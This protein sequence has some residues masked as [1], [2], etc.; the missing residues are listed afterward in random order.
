MVGMLEGLGLLKNSPAVKSDAAVCAIRS[1][2]KESF[3]VANISMIHS[4]L[5][6]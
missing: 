1:S 4:K 2:R 3:H 5:R 6:S